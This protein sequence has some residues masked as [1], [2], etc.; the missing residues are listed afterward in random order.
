MP[1]G[2]TFVGAYAC[3]S[4]TRSSSP[5]STPSVAERPRCAFAATA[6]L[7]HARGRAGE[8]GLRTARR[9]AASLAPRGSEPRRRTTGGPGVLTPDGGAG[10]PA[11]SYAETLVL[12]PTGLLARAPRRGVDHAREWAA[13]LAATALVVTVVVI[14]GGPEDGWTLV[15]AA[16]AALVLLV[17]A[18]ALALRATGSWRRVT[19]PVTRQA[20]ARRRASLLALAAG[21]LG[22]LPAV[23]LF[24]GLPPIGVA[25][26][27]GFLLLLIC[28]GASEAWLRRIERDWAGTPSGPGRC[29]GIRR[30]R[31]RCAKARG[32][33]R[34]RWVAA[35]SQASAR[36]WRGHRSPR[37]SAPSPGSGR[38]PSASASRETTRQGAG[39]SCPAASSS[40]RAP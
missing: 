24:P 16:Q 39:C 3:A 11:P 10:P 1:R 26:W 25:A 21:G 33:R 32:P 4:W 37:R 7:G 35:R 12:H 18:V 31:T 22:S 9:A 34:G 14:G 5:T 27:S 8:D 28:H 6:A 38:W 17:M 19:R 13:S 23:L 15:G 36:A 20:P 2:E 30:C 29:R 40:P